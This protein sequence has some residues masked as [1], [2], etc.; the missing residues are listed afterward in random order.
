MLLVAQI[1]DTLKATELHRLHRWILGCVNS[2]STK[3]FWKWNRIIFTA[4]PVRASPLTRLP[5]VAPEPPLQTPGGLWNVVW[6]TQ[7]WFKFPCLKCKLGR[8]SKS[9]DSK[10]LFCKALQTQDLCWVLAHPRGWGWGWGCCEL[11]SHRP[12][13]GAAWWWPAPPHLA[14]TPKSAWPC[15]APAWRWTHSRLG[16]EP[17]RPLGSLQQESRESPMVTRRGWLQGSPAPI[18]NWTWAVGQQ[19]KFYLLLPIAHITT[20]T[21]PAPYPTI[22][23]KIVFCCQKGWGPPLYCI[24]MIGNCLQKTPNY[25]T[26]SDVSKPF[27]PIKKKGWPKEEEK[28]R[29]RMGREGGK[30]QTNKNRKTTLEGGDN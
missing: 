29:E 8:E 4:P 7:I 18:R 15:P 25:F 11:Q 1:C 5:L 17:G 9:F 10:S 6:K 3:L 19:V 26:K 20:W 27:N 21:T 16:P 28:K 13:P 2:V 22:H 14:C 23:G 30:K 24:E 12:Y